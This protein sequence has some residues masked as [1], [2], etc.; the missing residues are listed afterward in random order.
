[1]KPE[2]SLYNTR[3]SGDASFSGAFTSMATIVSNSILEQFMQQTK[4][5]T[6][7]GQLRPATLR[8]SDIET[9]QI[10]AEQIEESAMHS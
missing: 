8:T 5:R 9:T 2:A 3:N 7:V 1:M 4:R 6:A 10:A